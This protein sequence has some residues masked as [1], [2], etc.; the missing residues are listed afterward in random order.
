MVDHLP[1]RRFKGKFSVNMLVLESD[2][3]LDKMDSRR[4]LRSM[5]C[6]LYTYIGC[7]L[8]LQTAVVSLW[9]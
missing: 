3:F 1:Q 7:V 6:S 2:L 9:R 8:L 5:V 4:Y